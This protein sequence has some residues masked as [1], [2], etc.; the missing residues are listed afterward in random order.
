VQ[1]LL[2]RYDMPALYLNSEDY[3][4]WVLNQIETE[5]RLAARLGL[6]GE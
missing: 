2:E 5:E 1:A 4:R 6:R 3:T